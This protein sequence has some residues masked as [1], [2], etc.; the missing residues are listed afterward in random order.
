MSGNH[1]TSAG[2]ALDTNSEDGRG[3]ITANTSEVMN[4]NSD[5]GRDKITAED[6]VLIKHQA[7]DA[8]QG[9]FKL[10]YYAHNPKRA[11]ISLRR[12]RVEKEDF[13][14]NLLTTPTHSIT[15]TPFANAGPWVPRIANKSDLGAIIMNLPHPP[16]PVPEF[17][18]WSFPD[19]TIEVL[20]LWHS[21]ERQRLNRIATAILQ[22]ERNARFNNPAAPARDPNA[23]SALDALGQPELH[24]H[25]V[26]GANG[27]ALLHPVPIF[28]RGARYQHVRTS[29]PKLDDYGNYSGRGGAKPATSSDEDVDDDVHVAVHDQ[30]AQLV[31]YYVDDLDRSHLDKMRASGHHAYLVARS[32]ARECQDIGLDGLDSD[33]YEYVSDTAAST[34][35]GSSNGEERK[36]TMKKNGNSSANR[37]ALAD[38]AFKVW[39]QET[40]DPDA[41]TPVDITTM[42]QSLM[43]DRVE[44][45][46]G[47]GCRIP[48]DVIAAGRVKK[49]VHPDLRD[50][51]DIDWSDGGAVRKYNRWVV[52]FLVGKGVEFDDG[53]SDGERKA[54]MEIVGM[55]MPKGVDDKLP[56]VALDNGGRLSPLLPLERLL[57]TMVRKNPEEVAAFFVGDEDEDKVVDEMEDKMEWRGMTWVEVAEQYNALWHGSSVV[58]GFKHRGLWPRRKRTVDELKSQAGAISSKKSSK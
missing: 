29:L 16:T 2:E 58:N 55:P 48:K 44:A 38:I 49:L 35:T 57:I 32:K 14:H 7:S 40:C 41:A 37:S 3:A 47:G 12:Q 45:G 56:S 39:L 52:D 53:Y 4:T 17:F 24:Q 31:L 34:A 54:L 23:K 15:T 11:M 46:E 42:A 8:I 30:H 26:R 51:V 28:V 33:E 43:R 18:K 6:L 50:G 27:F 22:D 9:K 36:M 19:R 25:E 1:S 13:F 10:I 21:G 20:T 5:D